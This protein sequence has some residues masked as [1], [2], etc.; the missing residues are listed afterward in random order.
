MA[1]DTIPDDAA[2]PALSDAEQTAWRR[3][4]TASHEAAIGVANARRERRGHLRRPG[5]WDRLP[6]AQKDAVH[7]D[8]MAAIKAAFDYLGKLNDDEILRVV[9]TTGASGR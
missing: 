4:A 3:F 8:A 1:F 6:P 9:R 7:A 5:A 2:R